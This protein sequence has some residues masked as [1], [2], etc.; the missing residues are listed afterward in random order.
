M[1]RTVNQGEYFLAA[2]SRLVP[3]GA[4]LTR[5]KIVREDHRRM[6]RDIPWSASYR[7]ANPLPIGNSLS[8][9]H[10]VAASWAGA[11]RVC[12]CRDDRENC[13]N[14]VDTVPRTTNSRGGIP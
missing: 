2:I 3:R 4:Q 5:L 13:H 10:C 11:G 9:T 1:G 6:A 7:A 8:V 14:D 12:G